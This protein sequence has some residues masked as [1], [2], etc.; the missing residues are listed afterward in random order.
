[1]KETHVELFAHMCALLAVARP[2]PKKA[3]K[4][5]AQAD[6]IMA[7]FGGTPSDMTKIAVVAKRRK[8]PP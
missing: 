5:L 6:R 2:S 1:L 3:L 7:R 4:E 8:E